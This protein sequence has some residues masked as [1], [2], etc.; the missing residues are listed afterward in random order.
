MLRRAQSS[1]GDTELLFWSADFYKRALEVAPKSYKI[2][3]LDKCNALYNQA[4]ALAFL[5]LDPAH[6]LRLG[7][8]LNRSM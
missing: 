7:V 1:P 2:T 5:T 6:H 8:E 4:A 3:I